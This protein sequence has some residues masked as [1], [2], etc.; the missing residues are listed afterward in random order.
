MQDDHD[1]SYEKL[2]LHGGMTAPGLLLKAQVAVR[3]GFWDVTEPGYFELDTVA[4]R[5][6]AKTTTEEISAD[7]KCKPEK[8]NGQ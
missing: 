6:G 8:E 2:K 5:C 3:V 1:R 4:H 7:K